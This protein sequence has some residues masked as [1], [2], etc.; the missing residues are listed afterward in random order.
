MST[1]NSA[2]IIGVVGRSGSGKGL[3][4]K[5][6]LRKTRA[7]ILV[8][9]PLEQT[10]QYAGVIKG[11]MVTTIA[12]LVAAIKAGKKRLVFVPAGDIK[13][14]FDRFCR[15]AWELRG[16]TIVVEELSRVTTPSWAPPAWR[17][18][19]TAGRHQGLT[20]YG[21][22]QRPAQVDKDFFGNCSEVRTYCVG[23]QNDAQT[24]ANVMFIKAADILALPKF[25]YLHRNADNN[26]IVKGVVKLPKAA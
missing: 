12:A 14:A 16:W 6:E 1:A 21:T 5:G 9:S 8:W 2:R 23:Y 11:E 13:A 10:D 26:T 25:H 7:P 4:V 18:L 15:I 20:I 24:M 3:F 22:A 17:N 19:S